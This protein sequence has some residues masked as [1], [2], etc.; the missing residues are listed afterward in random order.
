LT[1]RS[2][3]PSSGFSLLSLLNPPHYIP[4]SNFPSTYQSPLDWNNGGSVDLTLDVGDLRPRQTYS[5]DDDELVL[6]LPPTTDAQVHG[7]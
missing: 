6:I 5:S 1:H 7:T 3:R 4:T 2:R